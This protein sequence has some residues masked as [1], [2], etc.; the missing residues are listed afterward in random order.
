MNRELKVYGPL[1]QGRYRAKLVKDQRYL[2]QLLVYIHLN[3]VVAGLA[4]DP[5]R[6]RWSGHRDVLGLR[7]R[8]IVDVDEVLR[9]FGPTR[10]AARRAYTRALRGAREEA[11]IG[12]EPGRLPWWR[13]GRPQREDEEDPD[14]AGRERREEAALRRLRERP[15]LDAEELIVRAAPELGFDAEQLASRSK[16]RE[17]SRAREL[18]AVLAVER[19]GILVKDLAAAL[20]KHPVT[21]TGWVMRG[22]GRRAGNVEM[23]ARLEALD[24]KLC[25][26][27][28]EED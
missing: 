13:M 22:S 26:G 8:P 19:Y 14:A 25:G 28:R 18:L 21:V 20:H 17:L 24:L 16:G 10:R 3:P 1:W 12:E 23:A 9:L 11:W 2:D 15:A 27:P 7:K 6:Y 4:E 5:S